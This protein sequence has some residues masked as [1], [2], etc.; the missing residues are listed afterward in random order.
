MKKLFR[1][2]LAN[3]ELVGISR[4]W[5]MVHKILQS[6]MCCQCIFTDFRLRFRIRIDL[7][8]Q[9][10]HHWLCPYFLPQCV[11]HLFDQAQ[12]LAF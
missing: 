6:L 9:I 7:P 8:P 2:F 10:V 12:N 1:V 5:H 3:Q 11:A 4:V